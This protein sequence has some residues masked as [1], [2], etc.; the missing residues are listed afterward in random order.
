MANASSV[1]EPVIY[2]VLLY[3]SIYIVSLSCSGA[4]TLWKHQ[5]N[6]TLNFHTVIV[7][8]SKRPYNRKSLAGLEQLASSKKRS[9]P[10]QVLFKKPA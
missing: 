4:V 1:L 2:H 5:E 7:T 3:H 9:L 6:W 10:T 8:F